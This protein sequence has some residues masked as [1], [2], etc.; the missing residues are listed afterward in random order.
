DLETLEAMG[1]ARE[2][3]TYAADQSIAMRG[4]IGRAQLERAVKNSLIRLYRNQPA[5]VDSLFELFVAPRI[6][7]ASL[8]GDF[9][10]LREHF[11][12]EGYRLIGNN[13]QEPRTAL[14]LGKDVR[15]DY[16]DSLRAQQVSGAV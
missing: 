5:V 7:D 3:L 1:V 11:K 12:R 9:S 13:F 10:A 2:P 14:Q 6:E 16:P 15:V 8:V 4:D